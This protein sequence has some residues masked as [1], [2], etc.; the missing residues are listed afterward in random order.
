MTVAGTKCGDQPL[1]RPAKSPRCPGAPGHP[2]IVAGLIVLAS[3]PTGQHQVDQRHGITLPAAAKHLCNITLD[4]RNDLLT[5]REKW[6][7][8]RA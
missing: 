6:G 7:D 3:H 5:F 4:S 8:A 2:L 1:P